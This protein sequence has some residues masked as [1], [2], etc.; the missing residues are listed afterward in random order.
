MGLGPKEEFGEATELLRR[1]KRKNS[2]LEKR[3]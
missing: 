3:V 1:K 2:P